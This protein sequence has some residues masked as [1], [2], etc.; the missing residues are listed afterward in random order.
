MADADDAEIDRRLRAMGRSATVGDRLDLLARLIDYWHGPPPPRRRAVPP[1]PESAPIPGPLR[2]WYGRGDDRPEVFRVQNRLLGPRDLVVEG[3]RVVF[4]VENQGVYLWATE[5]EG[6]DP[7]V[8]GRFADRKRWRRQGSTLS[9]HLILACLLEAILATHHR[10]SIAW[11]DRATLDRVTAPLRRVPLGSWD[12]PARPGRYWAGGGAFVF[13]C[14]NE[15]PGG[16]ED[17]SIWVGARS[18]QPL[19]YLKPIV[20]DSWERAD[21]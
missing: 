3:G 18:R 10:A 2:W 16:G 1:L 13:A 5:P 11:A 8:W 6:D 17:S 9:G 15:S 21:L 7:P 12:W 4:H 14:P 20:D 19:A